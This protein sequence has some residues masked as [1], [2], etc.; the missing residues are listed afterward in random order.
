MASL[1]K[2][3]NNNRGASGRFICTSNPTSTSSVHLPT[4]D[5]AKAERQLKPAST[6]IHVANATGKTHATFVTRMGF[7]QLPSFDWM[8]FPPTLASDA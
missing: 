1:E 5:Y 3:P 6:A 8:P 7:I 2:R 4:A